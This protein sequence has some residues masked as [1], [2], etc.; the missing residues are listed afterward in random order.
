M[1]GTGNGE[2]DGIYLTSN[3]PTAKAYAREGV[4]LTCRVSLG[5][6]ATWDTAL[7]QRFKVWCQARGAWANNSAKTAFLL[8]LGFHTLLS[9]DVIVVLQPQRSNAHA[10]K[11]KDRRIQVVSVH[12]A[13]DDVR[14]R[15]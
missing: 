4:Y 6:S 15:V 9:G 8:S 10:W 14:V 2:G 11:R 5:R 7:R 3:L 12:R 1:V 13:S